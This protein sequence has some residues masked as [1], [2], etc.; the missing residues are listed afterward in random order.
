MTE[1][2]IVVAS[3]GV[4]SAGVVANITGEQQRGSD[5]VPLQ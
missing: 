4:N 3:I 2:E 5:Q 1:V